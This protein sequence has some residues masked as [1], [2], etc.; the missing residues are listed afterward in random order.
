[1]GRLNKK[2][3]P[4]RSVGTR[5]DDKDAQA[6]LRTVQH[7]YGAALDG[8][9]AF[10]HRIYEQCSLLL[11]SQAG[12]FLSTSKAGLPATDI[13][14]LIGFDQQNVIRAY[15]DFGLEADEVYRATRSMAPGAT[16]L[17]TRVIGEALYRS[18]L[19]GYLGGP[20]G[21]RF[22]FGGILENDDQHYS[23]MHFWRRPDQADFDEGDQ[24]RLQLVLPHVRQALEV[25]RRLRGAP[26]GAGTPGAVTLANFQNSRHGILILDDQGKVLFINQEGERIA[27]SGAGIAIRDGALQAGDSE[28]A[29][30]IGRM[31]AHSTGL[32]R[33][34]L[35]APMRPILIPQKPGEQPFEIRIVPVVD[36][37]QRAVLPPQAAV[38]VVITDPANLMGL[39]PQC[40]RGHGL[41]GAEARLCQALIRTGSLTEAADDL[42]ISASTARSH[43]KRVFAKLHVT[44]QIQ[45]V[46]RLVATQRLPE[47]TL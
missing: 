36:G 43:L 21:V 4:V 24:A 3:D 31:I 18:P 42:H 8:T 45:L 1:V 32:A 30:E 41:T 27:R 39:S 28:A 12:G 38:M 22:T 26:S 6:L 29:A 15:Q 7:F 46:T 35:L 5:L 13:A 25:Q 20:A 2:Q 14:A 33:Q 40:L 17:G 16:Y 11:Q 9:P 23:A 47:R 44:S 34:K 19:Y 10:W 37:E